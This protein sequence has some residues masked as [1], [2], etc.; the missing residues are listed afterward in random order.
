MAKADFVL[1][2]QRYSVW[3]W[4]WGGLCVRV[5][6]FLLRNFSLFVFIVYLTGVSGLAQSL[7]PAKPPAEPTIELCF[8]PCAMPRALSLAALRTKVCYKNLHSAQHATSS[9]LNNCCL[10]LLLNIIFL[11]NFRCYLQQ[12]NVSVT[13]ALYSKQ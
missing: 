3:S 10:S 11:S 13:M 7:A 8:M 5:C 1:C 9:S 12:T 4:Q 2:Y 6:N